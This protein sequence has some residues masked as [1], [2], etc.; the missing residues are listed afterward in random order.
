[1]SKQGVGDGKLFATR[2]SRTRIL[3]L[4]ALFGVSYFG[5]VILLLSLLDTDYNPITQAASDYGVGRYAIA[6]NLGFFIAGIG[7]CA[8]AIA[9]V[10]QKQRIKSRVGPAFLFVAGAVLIVDSYFTTNVGGGPATLHGTI[11]GFGGFFF[12][13]TAPLGIL[14]VS[15]RVSPRRTL[16]TLIGLV[17]GFIV[18]G[19]PDNAPG[20]AE[21]L[22]LLVIFSSIIV[23]SLDLYR[24]SKGGQPL[25]TN[26]QYSPIKSIGIPSVSL[27]AGLIPASLHCSNDDRRPT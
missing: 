25:S 13:I 21:R 24:N 9:N 18:L 27:G 23:A 10:L 1:M 6:M 12:F 14:L 17:I 16:V 2:E 15:R 4:V 11:H 8:F 26:T 19:A 7:I 3:S 20:L 22:I 5:S